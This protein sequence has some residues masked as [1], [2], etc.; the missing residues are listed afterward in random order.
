M[1]R[2]VIA[3]IVLGPALL[4]LMPLTT[5]A[6]PAPP[7]PPFHLVGATIDGIHAA[8]ASGQLTCTR[9]VSRSS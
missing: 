4:G 7:R 1:Y 2:R 9:L 8:M 6:Q 3:R 5:L